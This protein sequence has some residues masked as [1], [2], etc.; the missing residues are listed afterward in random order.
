MVARPGAAIRPAMSSAVYSSRVTHRAVM[1]SSPSTCTS[2]V[3]AC[4]LNAIISEAGNGH[5]C[6]PRYRTSPSLMPVSSM[7][8]RRQ[9][10]SRFSPAS[11]N[12]ADTEYS[13]ESFHAALCC[14]SRRSCPSTMAVM[15][16]GS[17]RGNSTRLPSA[18]LVHRCA[19]PASAGRTAAP[20]VG[21]NRWRLCQ[22]L[23]VMALVACPASRALE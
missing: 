3:I 19:H 6:E 17:T 20:Q 18:S 9:A 4:A 16:A 8:S 21:Q 11:T 23:K 13:L 2:V 10:C 7:A 14:S 12:P 22:M 5:G 1:V 15:T